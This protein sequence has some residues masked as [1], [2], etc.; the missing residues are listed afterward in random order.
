MFE[1]EMLLRKRDGRVEA[2]D[3]EKL[4]ISLTAAAL[5]TVSEEFRG[6]SAR[7]NI[8]SVLGV[9]QTDEL[10]DFIRGAYV[11]QTLGDELYDTIDF[12][13]E[14]IE[15][16]LAERDEII[17]TAE[18]S[19]I[20]HNALVDAG[21]TAILREYVMRATSRARAI[22]NAGALMKAVSEL[23]VLN[24]VNSNA[25][26]ENA[27]VNGETAMGTMLQYGATASKAFALNNLIPEHISEAHRE[28]SIHIHDLDFYSLTTT[29]ISED[30]RII[31]RHKGDVKVIRAKE[32]DTILSAHPDDTVVWLD[33][34]EVYSDGKF[35]K[36]KNIVRHSSK[37]KKMLRISS[38]TSTL[39]VTDD[40]LVTIKDKGV[41]VDIE[42]G[43]LCEGMTLVK[44][45]L[46]PNKYTLNSIDLIEL[47]GGREDIVIANTSEILDN[48][49]K[50]KSKWKEFCSVF[51]YKTS[52]GRMTQVGHRRMTLADYLQVEHLVNIPREQ[53]ELVHKCSKSTTRIRARVPLTAS[54]GR[55]IGYVLGD[56]CVS[57]SLDTD[58]RT[59]NKRVSYCKQDP[60]IKEDFE[61]VIMDV[62]ESPS[63]SDRV[64]DGVVSGVNLGGYIVYELFKG[65]FGFKNGAGDIKLPEWVYSANATF[66]SGFL[67]ALV[68]SDGYVQGDGYRVGYTSA[69]KEYVEG[70]SILL[71][72][73]GIPTHIYCNN[74]K[75]TVAKFG[76]KESVRNHDSYQL[77]ITGGL[78]EIFKDIPSYKLDT[79]EL[80]DSNVLPD[81]KYQITSIEEMEYSGYVYDMETEDSHFSVNGVLVHNCTQI[82]LEKLFEEGFDTGHGFIRTP[83]SIESYS[84][85]ACI[86]I[87]SNQN[88]QHGGQSI[89]ALDHYLEKG[90]AKTLATEIAEL[91]RLSYELK[92]HITSEEATQMAKEIR[93]TLFEYIQ[94]NRFLKTDN[95]RVYA[96]MI[97]ERYAPECVDNFD[98][99]WDSAVRRVERRTQQAMESL[100]HNLNSLH[101]R[102]GA[103][104]PFSSINF[105]TATSWEG[106]LVSF[107][108]L[109]AVDAGLGK[110]ETPIFPISIFK[111]KKGINVDPEDP[112]YDLFK[113]SIRTTAKRMYPNFSN[114]DAPFN[115]AV[116]R[117]GNVATEAAYM[118]CRTR[119][120]T[121]INGP[122]EVTRRGNLSF[123]TINLPRIALTTKKLDEFYQKLDQKLE[124]VLEQLLSRLEIVARRRVANMPFLM[125]QHIWRGSEG[126]AYDD[127]VMPALKHG[128]LSI[129][130]AGLAETLVALTGHHHGESDEAQELGLEIIRYM[131]K[132]CDDKTKELSLNVTLLATPAE[133][134]CGRFLQ[135]DRK[136][137]GVIP[138]V[139]DREYYT[140]SFHVPV[141]YKTN[142][143]HKVEIE[144]PY[145]AL[146]NAGHISYLELD[147]AAIDNLDAVEDLVMLMYNKGCG[148]FAVSHAIDHDPVCGYTGYIGDGPCPRCGRMEF[149]EVPL[150]RVTQCK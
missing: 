53:L 59:L 124:L 86:V 131:R 3:R 58:G 65:P 114:L 71:A 136:E 133:S 116:Y 44:A 145:H 12:V 137:F 83:T 143:R 22:E 148:Y 17:T 50:D 111:M 105:G 123:T 68:D 126:L 147:G 62:F 120:M 140:N 41:Q 94:S 63:Y 89:P 18:L 39:E 113:K 90:V 9:A 14:L 119:V 24:S 36:L 79:L 46:D 92:G 31:I 60:T 144:A 67:G 38:L 16:A 10:P 66:L 128:T 142:A 49:R 130:F 6:D 75:G 76:D 118:G 134:A 72:L 138:G 97:V 11:R 122:D 82:D 32:L 26:R 132:F 112:N 150:S 101:A 88:E 55:F 57:E 52:K 40:H 30:S 117:A 43:K 73:R 99:I 64:V 107:M 42:A 85:L 33:G 20:V 87:Q 104:V 37:G 23:T 35:V 15:T 13:V 29:C 108:F 56:G 61:R 91:C 78:N 100:V 102:A 95:G 149:E 51:S 2:Y 1:S 77:N 109:E 115:L 141:W 146:T 19:E 110:G 28:G 47:W 84:A 8:L 103:Q 135:L 96:K 69:S 5:A 125:G 98:T 129:G 127:S 7:E 48:L 34:Y 139:T 54:L 21:Q 27:N 121:D 70:L 80:S 81:K 106:R 45:G 25:K 93:K 4:R 74:L